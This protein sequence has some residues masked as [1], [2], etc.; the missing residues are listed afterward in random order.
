MNFKKLREYIVIFIGALIIAF[1]VE[2]FFAQHDLIT[3]GV[4]G[5]SIIL[6]SI[7][8]TPLWLSS[9]F[10]NTPLFL[11]GR[12]IIGEDFFY[13][14]LVG[15]IGTTIG[16]YF[17]ESFN[18]NIY[19]DLFISTVIG[20]VVVGIGVGLIF[21][22]QGSSGGT[23]LAA[24]IVYKYFKEISIS[25]ILFYIDTAVILLGIFIFGIEKGMYGL[26]AIFI[27][28]KT[29]SY[30]IDG[31]T[32]AKAVHIISDKSDLIAE[33]LLS[34]LVRGVTGFQGKGMYT[35]ADKTILY[36][37][38][39]PRQVVKL[40]KIVEKIDENAFIIVTDAKEVQGIGFSKGL[41]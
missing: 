22:N 39:L 21:K 35:K 17:L 24:Q 19:F 7:I 1:G 32:F 38:V 6:E 27:A 12:F 29:I 41:N 3:G 30:V 36:C 26:I 33:S 9:I 23:D 37:V 40:K 15:F 16:F 34:D 2:V 31:V 18:L 25:S 5:I 14:S 10:I 28:T 8:G 4:S 11:V 13:K 20:A